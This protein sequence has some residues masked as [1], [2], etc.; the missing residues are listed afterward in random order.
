MPA[1]LKDGRPVD[2]RVT[3]KDLPARLCIV[4]E[5]PRI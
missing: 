1:R 3:D 2:F 4:A 5:P